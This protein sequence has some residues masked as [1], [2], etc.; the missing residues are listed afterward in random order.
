MMHQK[1][2]E[3]EILLVEDNMNMLI[4]NSVHL[5]QLIYPIT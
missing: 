2:N 4:R 3:V 5:V 1:F